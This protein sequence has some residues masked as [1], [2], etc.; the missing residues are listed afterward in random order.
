MK[1]LPG[2]IALPVPET[3]VY[4]RLGRQVMRW[5]APVAAIFG[6]VEQGVDDFAPLMFSESSAHSGSGDTRL[7]KLLLNIN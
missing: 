5:I 7:D 1:G 4:Q 2:F 3:V 6:D